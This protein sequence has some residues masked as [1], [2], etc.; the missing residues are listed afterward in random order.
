MGATQCVPCSSDRPI[1]SD[2]YLAEHLHPTL[3]TGKRV[4]R[5]GLEYSLQSIP[6]YDD[7]SEEEDSRGEQAGGQ[8]QQS[9]QFQ[10]QQSPLDDAWAEKEES[11]FPSRKRLNLRRPSQRIQVVPRQSQTQ[12]AQSLPCQQVQAE[13]STEDEEER[14]ACSPETTLKPTIHIGAAPRRSSPVPLPKRYKPTVMPQSLLPPNRGFWPRQVHPPT[15]PDLI[16]TVNPALESMWTMQFDGADAESE[17]EILMTESD[18]EIPTSVMMRRPI[19]QEIPETSEEEE[20]DCHSDHT[21]QTTEIG[22]VG[23]VSR[24][25]HRLTESESEETL[26]VEDDE[27]E[28]A[29]MTYP[30]L[31]D[32]FEGCSTV[33][34][35]ECAALSESSLYEAFEDTI[36][37]DYKCYTILQLDSEGHERRVDVKILKD[38]SQSLLSKHGISPTEQPLLFG[39]DPSLKV[40]R[41]Y[42]HVEDLWVVSEH[43]P[44]TLKDVLGDAQYPPLPLISKV[45]VASELIK[46]LAMLHERGVYMKNLGSASI[47]LTAD[48]RVCPTNFLESALQKLKHQLVTSP[49][50]LDTQEWNPLAS[51]KQRQKDVFRL[52]QLIGRLFVGNQIQQW[53][54]NN[55]DIEQMLMLER[56]PSPILQIICRCLRSKQEL[57]FMEEIQSYA[58]FFLRC[59]DLTAGQAACQLRVSELMCSGA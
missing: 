10:F 38:L 15:N 55:E 34:Y 54:R 13:M 29:T 14:M 1:P 19:S 43:I 53:I 3:N 57:V 31:L 32:R 6:E 51:D 5:K 37:T 22:I 28:R 16:A 50:Y 20:G 52:G 56:V 36:L 8:A 46:K 18:A 45:F 47:L 58:A 44:T 17:E 25:C 4:S 7:D 11:S 27:D 59:Y 39:L 49:E 33:T 30:G 35:S 40:Q 12:P 48:G 2:V 42:D 41:V 24:E 21:N 26:D 9:G 23:R